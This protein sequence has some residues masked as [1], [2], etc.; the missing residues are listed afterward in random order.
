MPKSNRYSLFANLFGSDWNFRTN[1]SNPVG[2]FLT[3]KEQSAFL[4]NEALQNNAN[5]FNAKE[6]QKQRDYEE[7]LS[8]TAIQR[9]V[10]DAK[11]AG[12][13]PYLAYNSGLQASTPS[14]ATATSA[15]ASAGSGSNSQLGEIAR[16]ALQ[17][18][19][20]LV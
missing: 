19:K 4:M 7:R 20:L 2:S 10:S 1:T 18:V 5:A 13:N 6:A 17:I 11:S 15:S 9:A 16:T 14:G 12:L 3:R 8:N